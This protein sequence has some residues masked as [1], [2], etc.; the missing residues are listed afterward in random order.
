MI[1]LVFHFRRRAD[2]DKEFLGL[3]L[4]DLAGQREVRQ[5]FGNMPKQFTDLVGHQLDAVA[6][7]RVVLPV[8][9]GMD[10]PGRVVLPG[11]QF[12]RGDKFFQRLRRG[13]AMV[14]DFADEVGAMAGIK[15]AF[16]I[17]ARTP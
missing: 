3:G 13:T 14:A 16:E 9:N 7:D 10:L 12:A 17:A 1:P 5:I 11:P 6:I 4:G 2:F 15:R 8:V